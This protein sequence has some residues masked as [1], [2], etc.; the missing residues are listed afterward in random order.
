M[1]AVIIKVVVKMVLEN[2]DVILQP[3][4]AFFREECVHCIADNYRVADSAGIKYEEEV[5]ILVGLF[6]DFSK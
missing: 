3:C 6:Q 1:I 4:R 2:R 5:G